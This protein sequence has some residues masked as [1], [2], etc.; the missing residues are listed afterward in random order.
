M[1][2]VVFWG[3]HIPARFPHLEHSMKVVLDALGVS[4]L[5]SNRFTC[6]PE[7]YG[8]KSLGHEAWLMT[9]GRNLAVAEKMGA[10][11]VSA[12]NGCY[13]NLK[14]AWAELRSDAAAAGRLNKY[15]S[16]FGLSYEGTGKVKHFIEVL[17]D[18]IT[19]AGIRRRAKRPLAG[20]KVGAH[21]GC[22]LLRPANHLR[23]DEPFVAKK[24]DELIG[25]TFAEPIK[26][27]T[28]FLCCGGSFNYA[29]EEEL[30]LAAIRN[31]LKELTTLGADC[32]VTGCPSCYSQFDMGQLL[33]SRAGEKFALPVL[34]YTEL[35][36]LALGLKPEQLSL[37][38]H[39]I[40]VQPVVD[41]IA[42]S[43]AE[44]APVKGIIDLAMMRSCVAC[45]A[46][47]NDCPSIKISNEAWHPH[48]IFKQILA[49]KLDEALASEELWKCLDCY[50]CSELCGNGIG[51]NRFFRQLR[52]LALAKGK[53]PESVRAAI[54]AFKKTGAVTKVSATTRKKLGLGEAKSEGDR[55]L[56]KLLSKLEKS[57]G[58]K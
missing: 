38:R 9:A 29:G 32:I 19:P 15:L 8:I 34:Y 20:L 30:S 22:H 12:C 24:F 53:A 10:D 33:L 50:T 45:S 5:E 40:S 21:P 35:V 23:F 51:M 42:A 26:Y 39:R 2:Y 37:D 18:D 3:C 47:D 46:C 41:K 13:S 6:C 44:I 25:A 55:E 7:N 48:D 17:Y 4:Y 52:E 27:E 16:E 58:E 28:K 36:G 49:G 31:K 57:I 56:V 1:A 14:S 11:I 43:E 54:D